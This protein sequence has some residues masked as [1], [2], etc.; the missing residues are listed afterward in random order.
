MGSSFV[1]Q[2][3]FDMKG[4]YQEASAS[5]PIFFVLFPGVDPTLRVEELGASFEVSTSAATSSTS[6]WARARRSP[7]ATLERMAEIGGW[8]MLQNVHLMQSW[9]PT[10]ER[11]LELAS[12]HAHPASGASS[13]RSRRPRRT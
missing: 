9:L 8:V 2:P 12:E 3:T 4:T 13:P 5:T 1:T 6:P 7:Q 11:K 10:F